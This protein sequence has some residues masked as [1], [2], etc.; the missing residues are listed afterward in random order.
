MGARF[1]EVIKEINKGR[2]F[3]VVSHVSPE[4][5]AIGSLLGLALA[6]R[7]IGKDVVAY[8]E[9]QVPEMF[10]FL[11]GADTIVHS[12][13]VMGPFDV[14]F[15]VDC[16]QKERLGK[17]FVALKTPGM[18]INMDHHATNDRFGAINVIE[19]E[20]SAAGELVYD[21]CAAAGIK[22]DREMAVNLYV[23]IHTDTGSFRYSSSSPA[24]FMKAGELVKAGADPW[25][26]SCRVYENFPARKYKLLAMVLSTLEVTGLDGR[27]EIASLVVTLDMFK[28]SGAETELSDG[29]VNYARGIEGVEAGVLFRECG[30]NEYK[31]SLRSKGAVNVAAIASAFNG[32]GHKNAAGFT[33]K[34]SLEEIRTKVMAAIRSALSAMP[35]RVAN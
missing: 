23:A 25:D 31:V 35:G 11:P 7:S 22:F 6:L 26:V 16:G 3:L 12:L 18:I 34:G 19:P 20:A 30:V 9:D 4:G 17:G 32:G 13:D 14:T 33:V 8:L 1:D 21:L 15:A 28:K 2:R 27:G 10:R 5:D 29:F 24:A